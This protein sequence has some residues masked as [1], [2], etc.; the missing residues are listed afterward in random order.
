MTGKATWEPA[1][2]VAVICEARRLGRLVPLHALQGR[3]GTRG[4]VGGALIS[5][6]VEPT[7]S[8]VLQ[9]GGVDL[10]SRKSRSSST[11]ARSAVASVTMASCSAAS[12][13]GSGCLAL[14]SPADPSAACSL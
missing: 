14:S 5:L 7:R 13:G 12:G 9:V 6:N 11:L 2:L 10:T 4:Q 8:H 1:A 3:R